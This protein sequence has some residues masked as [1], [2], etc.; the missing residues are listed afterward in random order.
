M[1]SNKEIYEIIK[2]WVF[3]EKEPR[4]KEFVQ[5]LISEL[6]EYRTSLI[7]DRSELTK[8][9]IKLDLDNNY[10]L[11]EISEKRVKQYE[12]KIANVETRMHRLYGE[13]KNVIEDN[14]K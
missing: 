13:L 1:I 8:E 11:A 4:N 9:I 2:K 12:K 14:T 7:S 6:N 10:M 3:T 5:Q